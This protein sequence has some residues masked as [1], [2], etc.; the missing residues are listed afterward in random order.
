MWYARLLAAVAVGA[1]I[2][3][4]AHLNAQEP[5]PCPPG[6]IAVPSAAEE[7]QMRCVQI[8]ADF[9]T[10]VRE[11]ADELTNSLPNFVCQELVYRER[12]LNPPNWRPLDRLRA[13]VT[14]ID[15]R[16][17]YS[18]LRRNGEPLDPGEA[19]EAGQWSRGE[20]GSLLQSLFAST[21]N[22]DFV[23]TGTSKIEGRLAARYEYE[24]P[25]ERS[26][27][28]AEFNDRPL[29][30]AYGG[31]VW[32]DQQTYRV[33]RVEM[34][35]RDLPNDYPTDVM[36]MSVDYGDVEIAGREYLLPVRS[37]NVV[38]WRG[39]RRCGRNRVEFRNYRRFSAESTL[40]LPGTDEIREPY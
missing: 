4:P 8:Q 7:P 29:N 10:L 11:L 34:Q 20:F 21:S 14:M 35:A 5:S 31:V 38:C 19:S 22:A 27:W 37:E 15:G 36:E 1:I 24:V 33:L 13:E 9:L 23:D 32:I 18:D 39:M 28:R 17:S 3:R 26:L 25:M 2:G 6:Y 30:P 40:I 16:E 12:T